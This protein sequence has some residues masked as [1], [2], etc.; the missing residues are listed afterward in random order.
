MAS[1][2]EFYGKDIA[3]KGDLVLT[4]SGD[5][6]TIDGLENVKDALLRRLVTTPGSL[7]HRPTYGVGLKDFLNG[8]NS[9]TMRERLANRIQEQFEQ[10]PRVEKVLGLSV[11]SDD[12]SPELVKINVRVKLVGYEEQDFIFQPFGGL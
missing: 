7:I 8:I 6:D 11:T 10:D 4:A 2:T 5:L 1:I 3:F 9:R 12:F